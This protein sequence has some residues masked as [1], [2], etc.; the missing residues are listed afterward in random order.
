MVAKRRI[1]AEEAEQVGATLRL[2]WAK[3]DDGKLLRGPGRPED[4]RFKADN[5]GAGQR[6]NR[7]L[8]VQ[9]SARTGQRRGVV[10]RVLLVELRDQIRLDPLAALGAGLQPALRPVRRAAALGGDFLRGDAALHAQAR[11]L[12]QTGKP[13]Y[14]ATGAIQDLRA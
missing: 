12:I 8:R 11:Q 1:T 14:Y 5:P 7:R 10:L 4:R 9:Q 6:A 13:I 3:V 2:D